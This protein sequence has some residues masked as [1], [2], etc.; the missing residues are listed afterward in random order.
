MPPSLSVL[1]CSFAKKCY[2]AP[3][4][5]RA[6][7]ASYTDNIL[8]PRVHTRDGGADILRAPL[9]RQENRKSRT[10]ATQSLSAECFA[11]RGAMCAL[12]FCSDWLP[13]ALDESSLS[14][15]SHPH[16]YCQRRG[17]RSGPAAA[18]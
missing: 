12:V 14:T 13:A 15:G 8:C 5:S 18:P 11:A 17:E 3:L 16:R 7:P 4:Q 1:A 6:G 9:Q 2:F 10:R